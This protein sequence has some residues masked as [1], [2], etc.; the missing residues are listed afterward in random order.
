MSPLD[1]VHTASQPEGPIILSLRSS[2]PTPG[3][4]R[5][6]LQNHLLQGVFLVA[7]GPMEILLPQLEAFWQLCLWT[8]LNPT[9]SGSPA[10]QTASTEMPSA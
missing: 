9:G 3:S 5:T 4:L 1:S 7:L 8:P 6:Q 10:L 2:P